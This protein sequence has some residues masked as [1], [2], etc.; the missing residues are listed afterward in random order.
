MS[1]DSQLRSEEKEDFFGMVYKAP[2][3]SQ[4]VQT[5][6]AQAGT[7]LKYSAGYGIMS[8]LSYLVLEPKIENIAAEF[9]GR[10]DLLDNPDYSSFMLCLLGATLVSAFLGAAVGLWEYNNSPKQSLPEQ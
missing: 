1:L 4:V 6:P 2:V 10:Y 7:I 9:T 5:G 3:E 8:F